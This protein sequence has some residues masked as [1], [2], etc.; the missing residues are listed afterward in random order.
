M[1]A[2]LREGWADVFLSDERAYQKT[3][4]QLR[5]MFQSLTG[6]SEPVAE[7]MASTFRALCSLADFSAR[8]F[9]AAVLA[10]AVTE[11]EPP[12][13]SLPDVTWPSPAQRTLALHSDVHI[14]LPPTS[15]VAVYTAIFRAL[16][17]ELLD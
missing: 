15:D 4:T 16:R 2:G 9:S 13:D 6:K 7:K 1:A 11:D 8:S 14:H 3:A 5:S 17:E 12:V 10:P